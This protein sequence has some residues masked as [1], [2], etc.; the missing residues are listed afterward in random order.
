MLCE[1]TADTDRCRKSVTGQRSNRPKYVARFVLLRLI[2]TSNGQLILNQL[3]FSLL[4]LSLT[5]QNHMSFIQKDENQRARVGCR[6][7][8]KST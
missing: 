5:V 8:I 4:D 3:S 2:G 1:E 7:A 6:P